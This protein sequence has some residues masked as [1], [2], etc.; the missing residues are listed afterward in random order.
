[1]PFPRMRQS[2]QSSG[3]IPPNSYMQRACNSYPGLYRSRASFIMRHLHRG[4]PYDTVWK[5]RSLLSASSSP[6]DSGVEVVEVWIIVFTLFFVN[7]RQLYSSVLVDAGV[8]LA[9][10]R[11]RFL[12]F[13]R[14]GFL[15]SSAYVLGN[16]RRMLDCSFSTNLV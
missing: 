8:V 13:L 11:A 10:H 2:G 3:W 4:F 1:M 16:D 5:S 7:W 15:W 14:R 6:V 9:V 12:C